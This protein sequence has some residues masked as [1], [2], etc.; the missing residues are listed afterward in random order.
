[1]WDLIRLAKPLQAGPVSVSFFMPSLGFAIYG[2]PEAVRYD[3]R[4]VFVGAQAEQKIGG[5]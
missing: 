2:G 1:V 5:F 3:L 4:A